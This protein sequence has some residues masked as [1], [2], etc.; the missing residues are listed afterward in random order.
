MDLSSPGRLKELLH[1][2]RKTLR[3]SLGQN[4]LVHRG[5]LERIIDAAEIGPDDLVVEIG[6]GAGILTRELAS[7]AGRVVAV[8]ID[9]SLEPVLAE[10]VTG[11]GAVEFVW[12][13]A[14]RLDWSGVIRG[15]KGPAKLVA[16]LPY[17]LTTPILTR[18]LD[19]G[20]PFDLMVVMVQREVADRM[21]S[22]PGGKTFGALSVLVQY[23]CVPEAVVPVPR[24]AFF[25]P[26]KVESAVIRLRR[27]PKPAV[28]AEPRAFFRVVRAAFGQRRKT[29]E[30]SLSGGLALPKA[31]AGLA[32]KSAGIDPS[33][34]GETLSLEE[35]AALTAF[36]LPYL[37]SEGE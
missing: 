27:R 32:L 29:L 9:R 25:P 2:H 24:N 8:E 15:W 3:H 33:R 31:T 30:N 21:A 16:N 12:A 35:F 23:W 5:I 36:L 11:S 6:P 14:S 37:F 20:C 22:P 18:I 34:R 28:E 13:D 7:R 4:F 26:P 10:A 19:S 17:Y 1:K